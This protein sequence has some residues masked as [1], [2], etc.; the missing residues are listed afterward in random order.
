MGVTLILN[1]S[2]MKIIDRKTHGYLDYLVGVLLVIS[3]WL[4]GFYEGGS[5]SWVVILLGAGTLLYSLITD[6][7]LGLIGI[8]PMKSHLRIDLISGIFLAASPWLF[9][10]SEDIF[11]PHVVFGIVEIL[12]VILTN[13]GS[14]YIGKSSDLQKL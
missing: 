11:W 4:F 3:P 2:I 14:Q 6:Y 10:F 5:E 8:I 1:H 9:G 12:V 13:P 7:E